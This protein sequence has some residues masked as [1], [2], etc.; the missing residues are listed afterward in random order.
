MTIVVARR[1]LAL[2]GALLAAAPV[3]AQEDR[4]VRL[5]ALYE[6]AAKNSPRVRALRA[7]AEAAAAREPAAGIPPD[8][9]LEV[10]AMNLSLPGLS[11]DMPTSMVPV[12]RLMQMV[13]FPGK[14]DATAEMA[15]QDTRIAGAE[16]DAMWWDTRAAIAMAFY[17]LYAFDAQLGVMRET[18]RLL[19]DLHTVARA[20]YASGEGRQSDVLRASV[21]VARMDADIRRMLAM[22]AEAEAAL[23]AALGD[24]VWSASSTALSPLP[25]GLPPTDTLIAWAEASRPMLEGARAM[26]ERAAAARDLAR[27]ELWPDVT[28]SVEYGQRRGDAGMGTER[29]VGVMLGFSLP[30]FANR[31]Q[32][33]MRAEMEAMERMAVADLAQERADV[34][35][36]I[37]ALVADLE[38]ARSLLTLYR[39]EILPQARANVESAYASYRTGSVDFMTVVDARMAVN[40]FEQEV[41]ELIAA[42]G[43]AISELEMNVG[44]ELPVVDAIDTETP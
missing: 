32:L 17:E 8:P 42:Y 9:Y 13:P 43:T 23:S 22:R 15:R 37:R 44:R 24:S 11:A 6:I 31:R 5:E 14:L 19:D 30:V 7:S 40:E 18:L 33:P 27:R 28:V 29:M 12:I 35:G 39:T 34:A 25:A 1:A 41:H 26:V 2:A 36:R 3:A 20:M 38:R 21:E 16:A 10:G 4:P